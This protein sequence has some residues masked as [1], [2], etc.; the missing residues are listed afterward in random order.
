VTD[1][2]LLT[3]VLWLNVANVAGATLRTVWAWEKRRAA[4]ARNT[5]V[6]LERNEHG[7]LT[8]VRR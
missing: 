4:R 3:T 1:H 8:E 2:V 5:T 7:N 6:Q